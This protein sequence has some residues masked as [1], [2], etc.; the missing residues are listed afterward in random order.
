MQIAKFLRI[1]KEPNEFINIG[2]S[3]IVLHVM[4]RCDSSKKNPKSKLNKQTF[5]AET[6]CL[7]AALGE[8]LIANEIRIF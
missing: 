8:L 4:S 2:N 7:H 1:D 5:N 3:T 6:H